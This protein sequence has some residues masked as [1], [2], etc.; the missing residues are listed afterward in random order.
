MDT[1]E[2]GFFWHVHHGILLEWCHGYKERA[3]FI[4]T[5]KSKEEIETRLRLFQPVKGD[6]PQEVVKAWQA[7]I[8]AERTYNE[9]ERTYDEA[10][11]AYIEAWQAYQAYYE[12][13]QAYEKARRAYNEALKRNMPAI[14]ALHAFECPDCP[15]NG[16]TIFPN[17]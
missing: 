7:F 17:R 2:Q 15:W 14:M 4:R 16:R 1:Q 13:G 6:L 8:E 5:E 11:R 10:R 9:A 3:S 12:T